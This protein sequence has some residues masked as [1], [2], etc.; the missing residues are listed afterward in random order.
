M[1]IWVTADLHFNHLNIIKYCRPQFAS[2][3]EMNETLIN[4]W[5]NVIDEGDDVYVLGDFF[6]GRLDD[7]HPILDRLKGNIQLIKGNHD[8]TSNRLEFYKKNRIPIKPLEILHYN[9]VDFILCHYPLDSQEYWNLI[10]GNNKN[11]ILLYGH[12]HDRAP[13][14]IVDNMFHVGVDTNNYTPVNLSYI[15]NLYWKENRI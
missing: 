12:I 15:T 3:E 2:I 10:I 13:Q 7:I 6:M 1:S 4:N 8:I 11:T 5:N 9:G 14:G